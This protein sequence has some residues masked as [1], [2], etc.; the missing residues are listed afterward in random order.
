MVEVEMD[1]E[2]K[3]GDW[4]EDNGERA[5]VV[6]TNGCNVSVYVHG[7]A[8]VR[9]LVAGHP[10]LAYLPGC[11]GWDWKQ[12][13]PIEAG[14]GY[15]LI[16]ATNDTWQEGDEFCD[17]LGTSRLWLE[18][19]NGPRDGFN[20]TMV[21]RRKV[22]AV[23]AVDPGEGYRLIDVNHDAPQAGDEYLSQGGAWVV[24]PRASYRFYDVNTYRRRL[25]SEPQY[26]PFADQDEFEPHRDKWICNG[27]GRRR[28]DFYGDDGVNGMKWE[29]LFRNRQF[30]DGTPCGVLVK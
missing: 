17:T 18:S 10:R 15:R 5:L 1:R 25:P 24:L 14:E 20:D 26:R 11:T 21:Y 29:F 27:D 9:W 2:W 3:V 19:H 7:Y 22:Q 6:F 30:E 16:D 28:V 8:V 23:P 12:P 4:C 13:A